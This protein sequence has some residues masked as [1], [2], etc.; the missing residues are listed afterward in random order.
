MKD[1]AVPTSSPCRHLRFVELRPNVVGA[2]YECEDD[3]DD[4][5]KVRKA[6]PV[7]TRTARQPMMT[8]RLFAFI[9][10]VYSIALL[11]Q[12]RGHCLAVSGD[13]FSRFRVLSFSLCVSE[14]DRGLYPS[15]LGSML[16]P[17]IP[18]PLHVGIICHTMHSLPCPQCKRRPH[19]RRRPSTHLPSF[20]IS[21]FTRRWRRSYLRYCRTTNAMK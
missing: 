4:D 11:P 9:N 17:P 18:N 1:D 13:V 3:D 6:L 20:F 2:E 19:A 14:V 21:S 5:D 15:V 7:T 16:F 8:R 10:K 12:L